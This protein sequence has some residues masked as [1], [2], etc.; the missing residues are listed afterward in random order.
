MQKIAKLF[1]QVLHIDFFFLIVQKIKFKYFPC[2]KI[3]D[4][5]ENLTKKNPKTP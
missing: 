1:E 2:S 3:S 4:F 5:A